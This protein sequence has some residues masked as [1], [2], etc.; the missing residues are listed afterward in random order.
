V[1]SRHTEVVRVSIHMYYFKSVQFASTSQKGTRLIDIDQD[2]GQNRPLNSLKM[3]PQ[4][5]CECM[6]NI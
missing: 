2:I 3:E 1:R 4:N 5:E 6:A